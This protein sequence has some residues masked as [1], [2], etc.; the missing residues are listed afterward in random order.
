[1]GVAIFLWVKWGCEKMK[2]KNKHHSRKK[3]PHQRKKASASENA[4]Q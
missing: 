3:A 2:Q 1:M 4:A